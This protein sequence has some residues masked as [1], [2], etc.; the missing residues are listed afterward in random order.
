MGHDTIP[1]SKPKPYA[2]VTCLKSALD[3]HQLTLGLGQLITMCWTAKSNLTLIFSQKML[4]EVINWSVPLLMQELCMPEFSFGPEESWSHIAINNFPTGCG[5]I[6]TDQ[7]FNKGEIKQLIIDHIPDLKQVNF[8]LDPDWLVNPA[9]LAAK[10]HPASAIS[11]AF[12]NPNGKKAEALLEK[13]IHYIGGNCCY[14]G[15]QM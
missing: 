5:Y 1:L 9:E 12:A 13:G 14:T 8:T 15:S 4:N 6:N 7:V 10:N 11:F 2:I 3:K